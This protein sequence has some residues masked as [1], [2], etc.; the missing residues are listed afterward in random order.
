MIRSGVAYQD[1]VVQNVDVSAIVAP[2]VI[3][4]DTDPRSLPSSIPSEHAA[5][6]RR[7]VQINIM[8][9]HYSQ[10]I[11]TDCE[12]YVALEQTVRILN[13]YNGC[14]IRRLFMYL[15]GRNDVRATHVYDLHNGYKRFFIAAAAQLNRAHLAPARTVNHGAHTFTA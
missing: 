9:A 6:W 8:I 7:L 12:V 13:A 3:E 2:Y 4:L 14:G 10:L 15:R 1:A 11:M 5:A